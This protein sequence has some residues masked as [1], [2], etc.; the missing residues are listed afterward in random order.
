MDE[1]WIESNIYFFGY[2]SQTL[3]A[4]DVE[5]TKES[6]ALPEEDKMGTE[7]FWILIHSWQ[8]GLIMK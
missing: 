4:N 1:E 7:P 5:N 8:G 2:C 3:M 6:S